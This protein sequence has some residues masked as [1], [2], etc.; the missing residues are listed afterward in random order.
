[1][2]TKKG[3]PEAVI[4]LRPVDKDKRQ[5]PGLRLRLQLA[6]QHGPPVDDRPASGDRGGFSCPGVR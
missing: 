4:V 1:M 2:A 3:T 5:D 6:A